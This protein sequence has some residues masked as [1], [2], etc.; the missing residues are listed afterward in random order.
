MYQLKVMLNDI[1]DR[2]FPDDQ[3]LKSYKAF[4]IEVLNKDYKGRHGDYNPNTRHIRIMNTYRD[5]KKLVVT[6]IHELAH[7]VNEMQGNTDCHGEGFYRN[8]KKLL[9]T[10]L[11]MNLFDKDEYITLI[12]ERRDAS[13]DNKV[14]KMIQDYEPKD[15]GYKKDIIKFTVFGGYDIK[16]TLKKRG[17]KFNR[18]GKA[19]EKEVREI[20]QASEE[21]WLAP[22][23]V[24]YKITDANQYIVKSE[25]QKIKDKEPKRKKIIFSVYNSYEIRNNLRGLGMHYVS[26]KKVWQ[27]KINLGTDDTIRET[28]IISD[29]L[30]KLNVPLTNFKKDIKIIKK[31]CCLISYE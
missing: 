30:H 31:P 20:D 24:E 4:Y 1:V 28:Q 13:D 22:L 27:I 29:G 23:N 8:Y 15:A 25:E 26:D 18:I 14:I 3:K 2:T 21:E 17:Y 9:Y 5:E 11:D 19:W 7:H 10:A 6:S 12:K 16:D